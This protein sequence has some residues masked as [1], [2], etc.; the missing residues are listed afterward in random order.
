MKKVRNR[1]Y[2]QI[3]VTLLLVSLLP[4]FFLGVYM[5][6]FVNQQMDAVYKTFSTTLET[7]KREMEIG[8]KYVDVS[9]IRLGLKNTLQASV[10]KTYDAVNFQS[11]NTMQKELKIISNT[12]ENIDNIYLVSKNH[13][14][15]LGNTSLSALKGHEDE[16]II[17]LLFQ[18]RQASFWYNANQYLY[19]C[20]R[21]PVN[22]ID[23][24]GMLIAKFD[25]MSLLESSTRNSEE[26]MLLVVDKENRVMLGSQEAVDVWNTL[27]SLESEYRPHRE[28]GINEIRYQDNKYAL[29][30]SV[31]DYNGWR[32]FLITPIARIEGTINRILFMAFVVIAGWLVTDALVI[33]VFSRRLYLPLD[34]IDMVVQSGINL[35]ESGYESVCSNAGLVDRLKYMVNKNVEMNQKLKQEKKEGK[36]LFLRKVYQGEITD[37]EQTV[38]EKNDFLVANYQNGTFFVMAIKYHTQFANTNDKQLYMFVL[39]N[40]VQELTNG[41]DIFPPIIIGSLMYL[42]CYI[43]ADSN[44]SASMKVQMMVLMIIATVKKYVDMSLNIGVSQGFTNVKNIQ[45]GVNESNR[46]L[47]DAIGTEGGFNFYHSHHTASESTQGYLARKKRIQLL[48]CVDIGER[49]ACK[50]ELDSYVQSLSELYYYMFKLEICKLVSEI[51][52]TYG[53]YALTPDYEKVGDIIDF[54]IAKTVNSYEK[55]ENYLWDYLL[56]PLFDTICNQA[57]QRDMMQQVIEYLLDHIEQDISLD[58]CARHFNY[59]ANYLSRWFKKKMGMTYTEFVTNK[60]IERC[61]ILLLESDASVNELAEQFGYSSPQNFIRVFKKYVLLTPGQFR[62][63]ERERQSNQKNQEI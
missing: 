53:D 19:M 3:M 36:Q 15:V 27:T 63:A 45:M 39:E 25:E 51:L 41:D 21:I 26:G 18:E 47:Q 42:T 50:K 20:K 52:G 23:G 32:Y 40:I 35:P 60:K 37:L 33:L 22:A 46:A 43:K 61:K 8:F 34:E 59:N 16:P 10:N 2:K 11:F 9:L 48:H 5:Y 24:Q 14:W 62:K 6:F 44:E 4:V 13:D 1:Y 12:E 49:D 55:L 31:S 7:Y 38:F 57:K 58:D 29:I 30:Q 54:D 17:E 56:E 28:N